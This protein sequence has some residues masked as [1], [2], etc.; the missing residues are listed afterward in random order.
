MVQAFMICLPKLSSKYHL[1]HYVDKTITGALR[2]STLA[3][4]AL[5]TL[6][7]EKLVEY[8]RLDVER[9]RYFYGR[10]FTSEFNDKMLYELISCN[11]FIIM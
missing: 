11:A 6:L 1:T 10:I 4:S 9:L 3:E 2:V 5:M 7:L 8:E